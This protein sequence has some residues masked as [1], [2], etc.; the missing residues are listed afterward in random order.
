[1]PHL[2]PSPFPF[3]LASIPIAVTATAI[4]ALPKEI[5]VTE[6]LLRP[7][8]MSIGAVATGIAGFPERISARQRAFPIANAFRSV[9]EA[10]FHLADRHWRPE[11]GIGAVAMEM[12][13]S[14]IRIAAVPKSIFAR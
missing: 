8:R 2:A 14:P 6:I 13:A 11:M 4:G 9:A 5:S 3:P 12:G 7:F 1:M 10:H